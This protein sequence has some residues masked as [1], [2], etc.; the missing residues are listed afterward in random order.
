M[1]RFAMLGL[2]AT[3]L[4]AQTKPSHSA[5]EVLQSAIQALSQVQSVEYTVHALPA[6]QS[7][8]FNK[9]QT[10]ITG[11]VGQ[12]YRYRARFQ[13]EGSPEVALAVSDGE[14]VRISA[15]GELQEYPTRTMEDRASQDALPT[16]SLFDPATY[17][18]ALAGGNAL[19]AGQDDV[20]GE[21]CYVVAITAL[22]Q[23]EV[24][25]DTQYYWISA[26]TGLPLSTQRYRILHGATLLTNRWMVSDIQTSSVLNPETFAY[27]PVEKD[28]AGSSAG[29]EPDKS[30]DPTAS[31]AGKQVPDLEA[32]DTGYKPVSLARIAKGK[33]TILTFWAPWCGPCVGEFPAFQAA[34]ARHPDELQIV[35]LGTQDS[36]LNVL[37]FIQKHPEY[38]FIF[39]TDPNIEDRNSPLSQFFAGEAI[40][41]NAWI[42]PQ[43]KITEYHMGSYEADELKDKVDTWLKQLKQAQ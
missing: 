21:L 29:P 25:S 35:A 16:L 40:P 7:R 34:L 39:L 14:K 30:G 42:D 37:S 6:T 18:K 43:G 19:Y 31:V 12:P 36:R 26:R 5:S 38:K 1:Y 33:A 24:G 4:S 20:G 11:A 28:S 9:G 15:N 3:Y 41:R 13:A 10:I 8:N 22:L 23:E 2:A 17:R 32:R 27:H